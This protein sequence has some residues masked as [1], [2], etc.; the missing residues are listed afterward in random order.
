MA[1]E[2]AN[3]PRPVCHVLAELQPLDG[4]YVP[5]KN[6][7]R[8]KYHCFDVSKRYLAFGA[9]TGDVFMFQRE[10]LSFITTV[11]NKEGSVVQVALAPNDSIIGLATSRGHV[12][13]MEHNA[14]RLSVQAHRLQLSY[15]HKGTTVTCLL[16]NSIGS[17]LFVG[18]NQGKVSVLNV[19]TSKAKSLFQPPPCTL[20]QLD[21]KIVQ[22][23]FAQDRL[24]A[25]TLTRCY[26]GD[27][28]REKFAQ[29]GKK[30]RDGEFG[31][32]FLPR[33]KSH[34]SASIYVARPGCRLW[35]AD[36]RGNVL[37]THQFKE[38]LA[39]P[40][41]RLATYRHD[42]VSSQD[43][44]SVQAQG[45]AFCRLLNLCPSE[46]PSLI[47]SWSA[48]GIYVLDPRRVK[49]VLW[50][51]DFKDIKDVRTFRGKMYV[52][53]A[54][55]Q[56]HA[57]SLLTVERAAIALY[58][59]GC[60]SQCAQFLL[61]NHKLIS[62]PLFQES[63]PPG[64]VH[65]LLDK[66]A[67][68]GSSHLSAKVATLA[69]ESYGVD[70]AKR[71]PK[72]STEILL[73]E[74]KS[75]KARLGVTEGKKDPNASPRHV[76][77]HSSEPIKRASPSPKMA[78]RIS[79]RDSDP[80]CRPGHSPCSKTQVSEKSRALQTDSA[81]VSNS[82]TALQTA[83]SS[84]VS[85]PSKS[86]GQSPEL[87]ESKTPSQ[88][89][90]TGKTEGSAS[91][92]RPSQLEN[93]NHRVVDIMG[94][95][96]NNN[97]VASDLGAKGQ[98][99]HAKPGCS[100]NGRRSSSSSSRTLSAIPASPLD[101]PLS[102]LDGI[103][104]D[105]LASMYAEQDVGY[106]SVYQYLNLGL[107]GAGMVPGTFTV[108]PSDLMQLANV[109][110]LAKI[111]ETISSKYSNSKEILLKNLKG[112][113]S[114]IKYFGI[115]SAMDVLSPGSPLSVVEECQ[116][117]EGSPKVPETSKLITPQDE[118]WSFLP[119]FGANLAEATLKTSQTVANP[120]V[121]FNMPRLSQAL[122]EWV[123]VLHSCQLNVLTHIASAD[124]SRLPAI[125]FHLP[126]AQHCDTAHSTANIQAPCSP[127][128]QP[129]EA[130]QPDPRVGLINS[131]FISDPFHLHGEVRSK[132]KEL[133]MLCFQM[134]LLGDMHNIQSLVADV[135]GK[136]GAPAPV[137][138]KAEGTFVEKKLSKCNSS[139]SIES[140][141][142]STHC[143]LSLSMRSS[144]SE[145]HC[146]HLSEVPTL[147]SCSESIMFQSM[148]SSFGAASINL[149]FRPD[150]TD[151]RVS[152]QVTAG[153][154]R[155]AIT[156]EDH[157]AKDP[158]R[159]GGK[160][161]S[162]QHSEE[163]EIHC[164]SQRVTAESGKLPKI[165]V[166]DGAIALDINEERG[167][168]QNSRTSLQSGTPSRERLDR[169][170][171][172]ASPGVAEICEKKLSLQSDASPSGTSHSE[173]TSLSW[174]PMVL[175]TS[176][177]E[178]VLELD[179]LC[180]RTSCFIRNYFHLL[181]AETVWDIVQATDEPCYERWSAVVSGLYRQVE[182]K[183][184]DCSAEKGLSWV[185]QELEVAEKPAFII[186]HLAVLHQLDPECAKEAL[187]KKL[188]YM[189]ARDVLYFTKYIK[190][191]PSFFI[192]AV[193]RALTAFPLPQMLSSV[194]KY[195]EN[196]EVR[197][198][199]LDHSLQACDRQCLK[200]LCGAP[201]AFSHKINWP[202][203]DYLNSVLCNDQWV[204]VKSMEV[205]Q[206]YGFWPGYLYSLKHLGYRLEH[207][208]TVVQLGDSD[209]LS[210]SHALG[211][212]PE[213]E[214]E[215]KLALEL[216]QKQKKGPNS[217]PACLFCGHTLDGTG[218]S[219]T[220]T[221]EKVARR[222]LDSL[223]PDRT[224]DILE[225]LDLPKGTLTSHFFFS[226]VLITL[227]DQQQ[228][229]LD[230]RILSRLEG[231][232]WSRRS[233]AIA[234][235]VADVLEREK[236]GL[237]STEDIADV[238][239]QKQYGEETDSHWGRTTTLLSNCAFCNQPLG[240]TSGAYAVVVRHCGHSFHE[241]CLLGD[242]CVVCLEAQGTG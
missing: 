202:W 220:L 176:G 142:T 230:H 175:Q 59:H 90:S 82:S 177:G 126:P 219:A 2:D 70:L 233:V 14:E 44:S 26:L 209:L 81:A 104:P 187:L 141:G 53:L 114:K 78:R 108:R 72:G 222:M 196:E 134:D 105:V 58:Q 21:S 241:C 27:T 100:T 174:M 149:D 192:K 210:A 225:G 205:C 75:I 93:L 80:S 109:A 189:T 40:P 54:N 63:I 52:Q 103:D 131:T 127:N 9:T 33:A 87:T 73:L 65:D 235:Q 46:N 10:P 154:K 5:L 115:E 48:N 64:L 86:N 150:E 102:P 130:L 116:I 18:D 41:T 56:F 32:C 16:W 99:G 226:S 132:A 184:L 28:L 178:N 172:A 166:G 22:L 79:R 92:D 216:V 160:T 182:A 35:E 49:I 169:V 199:W 148:S 123:S 36:L 203:S 51:D 227:I 3:V 24:L 45:A 69:Q 139:N 186:A 83:G 185:V 215:W 173:P 77:C 25:S 31:C 164:A 96:L 223:G 38:A 208:V 15:E 89:S 106:E 221:V 118:L 129:G 1:H 240:A 85:S 122:D 201:R 171:E 214:E 67:N 88:T 39:V 239:V 157:R 138:S 97:C 128:F 12:L 11:T 101:S 60:V 212:L 237:A 120:D 8:V 180:S 161:T 236:Q 117:V 94:E 242:F 193:H 124:P 170:P 165:A 147:D 112:L 76:R 144:P 107:Y 140:E 190:S 218:E 137:E 213:D 133:A 156:V 168:Q 125:P 228:L 211:L 6:T 198:E 42:Y 4:I 62:R 17:R 113:E 162:S 167:E 195:L 207:L 231:Y 91:L 143:D 181:D 200:C 238:Q 232:L 66:L 121:L 204:S 234:P 7:T 57:C 13:V 145:K 153:Q 34:E 55:N 37:K 183:F 224:S 158:S 152:E 159:D 110:D 111:R 229:A 47:L 71:P 98:N 23:D 197:W 43:N 61:A 191:H 163:H 19:S 179:T 29:V 50:N 20:M 151:D 74:S 146:F 155:D 84:G 194:R 95:Y 119:P 136:Y 135:E 68:S 188:Q 30:L 217:M 206:Q